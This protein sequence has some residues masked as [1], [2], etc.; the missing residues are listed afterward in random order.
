MYVRYQM[1]VNILQE[2]NEK[3]PLLLYNRKGRG[4]ELAEYDMFIYIAGIF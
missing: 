3:V 1:L 4:V 2:T